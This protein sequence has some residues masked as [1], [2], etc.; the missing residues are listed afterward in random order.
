M[1][2]DARS[3]LLRAWEWTPASSVGAG[4]TELE[5]AAVQENE[6]D[7]QVVVFLVGDDEDEDGGGANGGGGGRQDEL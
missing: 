3:L 7:R 2:A 5:L 1:G 4:S 6:E